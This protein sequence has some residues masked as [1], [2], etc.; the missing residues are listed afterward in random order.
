MR[1]LVVFDSVSV[2]G[3]FPDAHG[4]CAGPTAATLP[5]PLAVVGRLLRGFIR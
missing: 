4:E 5:V 3:D 2:G 1:R